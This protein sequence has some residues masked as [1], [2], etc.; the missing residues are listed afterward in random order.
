MTKFDR[1]RYCPP[2]SNQDWLQG[3]RTFILL[4]LVG[5]WFGACM[6]LASEIANYKVNLAQGAYDSWE[7]IYDITT[8]REHL[9]MFSVVTLGST[10]L[11]LSNIIPNYL[12]FHKDSKSIFL[13]HR[14]ADPMELHRRCI[15]LPLLSALLVPVSYTHL[16]LPTMAVV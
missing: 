2:G 10:L 4:I 16:T 13:M 15:T 14:L 1:S 9:Y 5:I 8:I 12:Y 6:S 7:N 11:L 3:T